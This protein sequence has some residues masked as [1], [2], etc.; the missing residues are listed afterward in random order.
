MATNLHPSEW[1][2]SCHCHWN[3]VPHVSVRLFSMVTTW[4]AVKLSSDS[5]LYVQ[6]VICTHAINYVFMIAHDASVSLF[7]IVTLGG[8]ETLQYDSMHMY[9]SMCNI[10]MY[11]IHAINY[12]FMIVQIPCGWDIW[13]LF[14][15]DHSAARL[16]KYYVLVNTFICCHSTHVK[17]VEPL[18]LRG[19]CRVFFLLISASKFPLSSLCLLCSI[20]CM[21]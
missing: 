18:P 10:Y 15:L 12:V 4:G 16:P 5:M 14:E 19:A 11:N 1:S 9:S 7:S 21:Q 2:V 3:Y 8:S 13:Q 20:F 17:V 6:H